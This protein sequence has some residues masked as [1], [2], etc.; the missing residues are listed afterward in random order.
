M[1][2][3]VSGRPGESPP[4]GG[5][6]R[7]CP[8]RPGKSAPGGPSKRVTAPAVP[9]VAMAIGAV[10]NRQTTSTKVSRNGFKPSARRPCQQHTHV[11]QVAAENWLTGE[12]E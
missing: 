6:T 4:V 12:A 3:E 11:Q 10:T 7:G 1:G 5:L 8:V 9:T 2:R